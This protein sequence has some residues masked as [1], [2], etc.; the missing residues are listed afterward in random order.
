MKLLAQA[1]S[2]HLQPSFLMSGA[3]AETRLT[4]ATSTTAI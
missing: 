3:M 2:A 4:I 1:L